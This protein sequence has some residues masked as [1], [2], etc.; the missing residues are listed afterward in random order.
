MDFDDLFDEVLNGDAYQLFEEQLE[1]EQP[2]ISKK[3]I[4]NFYSVDRGFIN[5]KAFHDKFE[6]LPVNRNVQQA[7]YIQ[8]GR[9]LNFVDGQ[10]QERMLAINARTGEFLTDNFEREG[11]I[12]G[13]GFQDSEV[14]EIN[15]CK[16]GIILM[17]NHSLNGRP[18]IQDILTNLHD[19]RVRLSVICCHD[20]TVYGICEVNPETEALYNH[21]LQQEKAQIMDNDKARCLAT[22]KLYQ[23][24]D[25]L[26]KQHRLFDVRRL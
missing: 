13:T 21:F 26:D 16:D 17:H 12:R 5:S 25:M 15:K 9:L 11:S 3:E 20:G 2:L 10:E 7:L 8:A 18:S 6:R 22:T 23:V 4:Q 1:L 24:N 19:P 14:K